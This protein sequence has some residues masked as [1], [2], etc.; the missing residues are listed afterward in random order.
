MLAAT[1]AAAL[2]TCVATGCASMR[3][4]WHQLEDEYEAME[5][6]QA[7][8]LREEFERLSALPPATPVPSPH[9]DV[10]NSA[11]LGCDLFNDAHSYMKAYVAMSETSLLYQ[12]YLNDA[13]ACA[14]EEKISMQE[15][16]KKIAAEVVAADAKRPDDQKIWPLIEKSIAAA[17]VLSTKT[18]STLD[19]DNQIT[20]LKFHL[21]DLKRAF[22]NGDPSG[23]IVQKSK[24]G[25]Q[26]NGKKKGKDILKDVGKNL[27]KEL[28]VDAEYWA[29]RGRPDLNDLCKARVA[30]CDAVYRQLAEADN[31]LN[32]INE[33]SSRVNKLERDA[34]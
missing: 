3:N 6:R 8:K 30:E 1:S 13:K 33:Q 34:R 12:G 27:A 2:A 22:L 5:L 7:Q 23:R 18:R 20:N 16:Y 21:L 31:C 19:L 10:A 4:A 17:N 11:R 28:T 29:A 15:A 24:R 9:R 14:E 26:D 25:K 32:I